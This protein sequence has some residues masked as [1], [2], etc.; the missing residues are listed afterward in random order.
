MR[1]CQGFAGF[2]LNNKLFSNYK[3]GNVFS[4][5]R[6]ILIANGDRNLLLDIYTLFL[7]SVYQCVFINLLEMPRAEKTVYSISCFPNLIG[8]L[9]YFLVGHPFCVSCV[10]C[11]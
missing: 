7:E 4:D 6:F 9:E 1:I 5:N 3:V 10:F 8:K 2:Q 11:G